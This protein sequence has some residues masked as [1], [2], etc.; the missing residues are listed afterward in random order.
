M[1][2]S[3]KKFDKSKKSIMK[4]TKEDVPDRSR[5]TVRKGV[6]YESVK[7]QT[8]KGSVRPSSVGTEGSHGTYWASKKSTLHDPDDC[9]KQ[10]RDLVLQELSNKDRTLQQL[11]EII[12]REIDNL[13]AQ[14]SDE[15]TVLD[16]T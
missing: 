3:P 5:K 2:I 10:L 11:Q 4:S 7:V 13:Q 1:D 15:I 9:V 6:T 8:P 14:V 12:G 16:L